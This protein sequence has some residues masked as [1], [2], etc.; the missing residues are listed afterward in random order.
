MAPVSQNALLPPD[1][2][3]RETV[4]IVA[5]LDVSTY[6]I[7]THSSL[8]RTQSRGPSLPAGR[9]EH[10]FLVHPGDGHALGGIKH[11]LHTRSYAFTYSDPLMAHNTQAGSLIP[12][13]QHL[14]ESWACRQSR[15]AGSQ[16]STPM[17]RLNAGLLGPQQL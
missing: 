8:A 1:R 6:A 12:F 10:S 9:Q 14:S 11:R 15:D 2:Q 16:G 17:R 4:W 13:S 7:P 5:R 3:G